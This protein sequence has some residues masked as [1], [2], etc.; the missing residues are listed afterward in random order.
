[1]NANWKMKVLSAAVLALA[2]AGCTTTK[3]AEEAKPADQGST[4]AQTSTEGATTSAGQ[5]AAELEAQ[6][7]AEERARAEREAANQA[8]ELASQL[9]LRTFYFD[10]DSSSL[11]S[12]DYTALKAHA[13]YLAKNGSARVKLAGHADE[14]G[15]REYNMALGER[16]A[17][18]VAAFLSSNGAKSSQLN[19][20]S[21]GKEKPAAEGHDEESWA[22]N[23]RVELEYTAGNP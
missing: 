19:T 10:F 2:I 18:A 22:K 23:R 8:N 1:M 21:Y 6:R 11:S 20:V 16:R 3:K 7:L 14:R 17:K 9:G 4:Q 15:T 5:S 12:N 13:A